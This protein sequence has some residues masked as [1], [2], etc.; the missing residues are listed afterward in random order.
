MGLV[1]AVLITLIVCATAAFA[2]RFTGR[3]LSA[4]IGSLK[5]TVDDVARVAE[6]VNVAVNHKPEGEPTLYQHAKAASEKVDALES[7]VDIYV[8]ED[9]E[10]HD[11]M[12]ERLTGIEAGL[13][14]AAE[15]AITTAADVRAAGPVPEAP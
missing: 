10:A 2:I 6:E 11:A 1:T 7:K 3:K 5:V 8:A 13:A 9:R 15:L 14:T 12:T 4:E